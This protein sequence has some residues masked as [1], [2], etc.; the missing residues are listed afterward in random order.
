LAHALIDERLKNR[1]I[2]TDRA[3]SGLVSDG[4]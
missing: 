3:L 2:R 1:D 4:C